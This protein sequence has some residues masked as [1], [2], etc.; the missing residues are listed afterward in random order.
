MKVCLLPNQ[1]EFGKEISLTISENQFKFVFEGCRDKS[2][3]KLGVAGCLKKAGIR[4]RSDFAESMPAYAHQAVQMR[5]IW[6]QRGGFQAQQPAPAPQAQHYA[7]A[8]SQGYPQQYASAY[9]QV[10]EC[11]WK[12]LTRWK[13]G[14]CFSQNLTFNV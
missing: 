6:L 1:V 4:I 14:C 12:K 13:N 10:A 11:N 2:Q 9:S 5:Q 3:I 7:S 8:Y